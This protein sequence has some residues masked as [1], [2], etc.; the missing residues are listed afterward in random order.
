MF[1]DIEIVLGVPNET[2][3]CVWVDGG[4]LR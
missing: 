1:I 3:V 4:K 2:T